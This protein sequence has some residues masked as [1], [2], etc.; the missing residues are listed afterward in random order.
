[1]NTKPVRPFPGDG[2]VYPHIIPFAN[3]VPYAGKLY[4]PVRYRIPQK[5]ETIDVYYDPEKPGNYACYA[6]GPGTTL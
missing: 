2:A 4:I 3:G 5:V 1:M 6:F